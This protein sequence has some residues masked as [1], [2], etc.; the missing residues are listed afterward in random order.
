ML[1]L[2]G[3]RKREWKGMGVDDWF[4]WVEWGVVK[5]LRGWSWYG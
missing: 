1:G 5:Q 2:V 3:K 4:E